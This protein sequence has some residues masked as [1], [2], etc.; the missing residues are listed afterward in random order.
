VTEAADISAGAAR[1]D[2]ESYAPDW[3]RVPFHVGCSRC[4]QDL[5]GQAEPTCS[6]CGLE[7]DWSVV[8]PLEE[9]ACEHC[10]YHLYGL[11]ETRCPECGEPFTW[12]E[13]LDLFH[14]RHKPL[15]EYWW[16]RRPARSWSYSTRLALRP[17]KLWRTVD[18]HDPPAVGGLLR[19][20]VLAAAL[21]V[22]SLP[23]LG[24]LGDYLLDQLDR[25]VL[26]PSGRA[27]YG[28]RG[29]TYCGPWEFGWSWYPFWLV[30]IGSWAIASFLA[31]LV[32]QQSMR[33]CKVRTAHVFRV[34]VY[35]MLPV[36]L[37]PVVYCTVTFALDIGLAFA[38]LPFSPYD[39]MGTVPLLL[40]MLAWLWA[41][42][43][44][45][46]AYHRYIRMRHA[47]C[48]ALSTQAIAVLVLV[49]VWLTAY[50]L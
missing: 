3:D 35:A 47:W 2:G 42:L 14:R 5:R 34:F 10:G 30:N 15:F 9:L 50:W 27:V 24:A 11:T 31:L 32:F 33:L 22:A 12:E 48:V 28:F 4:G 26:A 25:Y 23:A 18:I 39:L 41:T 8:V 1:S 49:C 19:L 6:G 44:I 17:W 40:G 36:A 29:P 13:A 45:G 46:I 21:F 37:A 7:F 38:F 16:R 43:S 20:L